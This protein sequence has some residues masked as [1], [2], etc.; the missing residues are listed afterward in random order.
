[1]G[2]TGSL[3]TIRIVAAS[4]WLCRLGCNDCELDV[5]AGSKNQRRRRVRE[6]CEVGGTHE[7]LHAGDDADL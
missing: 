7:P 3:V 6:H 4:T 2:E 1:M 5:F